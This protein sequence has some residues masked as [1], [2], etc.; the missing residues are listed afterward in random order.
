MF[1]NVVQNLI[2]RQ[3]LYYLLQEKS[4]QTRKTR[5][6]DRQ[7]S[8]NSTATTKKIKSVMLNEV[9]HL[10]SMPQVLDSSFRCTALRMT[11]AIA[12]LFFIT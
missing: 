3:R 12:Q 7:N 11:P 10:R 2:R 1:E 4:T 8:R 9:K 6:S 5:S